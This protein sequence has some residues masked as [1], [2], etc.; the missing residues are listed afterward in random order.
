MVAASESG[1]RNAARRREWWIEPID[2]GI[3]LMTRQGPFSVYRRDSALTGCG[4]DAQAASTLFVAS[5]INDIL[6]LGMG[7][8]TVA[9]LCRKLHP[10]ARIVAVE[11]D[12][13]II[14]LARRRFGVDRLNLEI[15]HAR[16]EDYAGAAQ[17]CFDAIV[18]D[19]WPFVQ[20]NARAA[21]QDDTWQALLA[22]RLREGG[23]LAIN[24]LSAHQSPASRRRALEQMRLRFRHIREIGFADRVTTVLVGGNQLLDARSTRDRLRNSCGA[25][26][27]RGMRL[28]SLRSSSAEGA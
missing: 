20:A 23:A 27:V 5:Q 3:C 2:G 19:A 8:G 4:W 22:G 15:V 11:A 12:A 28:R 1:G 14:S 17:K 21:I 16:A 9:R 10:G 18:D 6:L 24:L 26:A 25:E 7:G 13:R